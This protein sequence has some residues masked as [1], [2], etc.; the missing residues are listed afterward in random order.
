MNNELEP[1]YVHPTRTSFLGCNEPFLDSPEFFQSSTTQCTI[2]PE[3]CPGWDIRRGFEPWQWP[4]LFEFPKLQRRLVN[5]QVNGN[6]RRSKR[7][8]WS[9]FWIESET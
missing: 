5:D 6:R 3:I 2:S 7:C 4:S 9:E 1:D 8:S